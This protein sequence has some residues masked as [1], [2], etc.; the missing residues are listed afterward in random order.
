MALSW[1]VIQFILLCLPLQNSLYCGCVLLSKYCGVAM[2]KLEQVNNWLGAPWTADWQSWNSHGNS[3][4]FLKRG[5]SAISTETLVP[6]KADH[7]GTTVNFYRITKGRKE[8]GNKKFFFFIES[9]FVW[10]P[11]VWILLVMVVD[12]WSVA[13][14]CLY[15]TRDHGSCSQFSWRINSEKCIQRFH[16]SKTQTN[17]FVWFQRQWLDA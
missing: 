7:N 6:F 5:L 1:S 12:Q 3:L 13:Y 17:V 9:C 11:H 2:A 15:T 4:L 16:L 8:T 14:T 10:A